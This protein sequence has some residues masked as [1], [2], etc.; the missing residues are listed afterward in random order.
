MSLFASDSKEES[1][2]PPRPQ[3]ER[4]A[5][6]QPWRIVNNDNAINYLD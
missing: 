6:S 2:C 4:A 3:A 1:L 5:V